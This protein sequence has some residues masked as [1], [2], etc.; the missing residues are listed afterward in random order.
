VVVRAQ[1]NWKKDGG[2]HF[3]KTKENYIIKASQSTDS[4]SDRPGMKNPEKP[5]RTPPSVNNA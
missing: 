3:E 2:D 4:H 1:W 5:L